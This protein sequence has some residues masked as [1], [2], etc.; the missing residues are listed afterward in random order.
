M[1]DLFTDN[2]GYAYLKIAEGCDNCCTYCIIPSLR[3]AY[4]SR[5]IEDIFNEAVSFEKQGVKGINSCCSGC[6]KVWN[7][8]I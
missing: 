7:R 6:Y 5:K 8:Y 2:K 1:K 3:G 4:R